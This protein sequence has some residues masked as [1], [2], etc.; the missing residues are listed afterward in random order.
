[1][2]C[3][4]MLHLS[5]DL[6]YTH[7]KTLP[8]RT[9]QRSVCKCCTCQRIWRTPRWNTVSAQ[10]PTKLL[11]M[12]HLSANL[13]Y[14]HMT[15]YLGASTNGVSAKSASA[16]VT[17]FGVHS[18]ETL[19]WH[20]CQR[21][22]YKCCTCQRIWLKPMWNTYRFGASATVASAN[23]ALVSGFRVHHRETLSWRKYQWS[24]CKA[25]L[26]YTHVKHG[27]CQRIWRTPTWNTV[28]AQSTNGVSTNAAPVSGFGVHPRETLFWRKYQQSVCKCC[29]CPL[30]FDGFWAHMFKQ[31]VR[32][33]CGIMWHPK[34][35]LKLDQ[36]H[37]DAMI[38]C[39]IDVRTHL[40]TN[41]FTMMLND[42]QRFQ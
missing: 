7:V 34:K 14:T 38:G 22:F 31:L 29:T 30:D 2:E 27:T 10:V 37:R 9:Y 24:V 39:K 17:G 33:L 40:P 28:L 11:Q 4:Q 23:V 3:L 35:I 15:H 21:S 8:W 13:A 16:T 18:R 6:A 25:D 42:V 26:A 41:L 32:R 20:K 5:A 1:M 12:L 36:R 19:C